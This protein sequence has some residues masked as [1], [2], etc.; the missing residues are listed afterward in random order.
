MNY[1]IDF[2]KFD[3]GNPILNIFVICL[4]VASVLYRVFRDLRKEFD[5]QCGMDVKEANKYY[6]K[7]FHK[8]E[9][10]DSYRQMQRSTLGILEDLS[11]KQFLRKQATYIQRK[12]Q[13]PSIHA[14]ATG[15]IR[16]D[17]VH[18]EES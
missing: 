4:I 14:C 9:A 3:L 1:I 8:K 6:R 15:Q 2:F 5:I 11:E 16:K 10:K 18:H 7:L 12:Q 13:G 17:T